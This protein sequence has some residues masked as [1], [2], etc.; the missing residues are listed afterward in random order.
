MER[1]LI[2]VDRRGKT[3][4]KYY[5]RSKTV[6][7]RGPKT[8]LKILNVLY[9]YYLHRLFANFR[10][11]IVY[12]DTYYIIP[13]PSLGKRL[14]NWRQDCEVVWSRWRH[15]PHHLDYLVVEQNARSHEHI[16]EEGEHNMDK[17]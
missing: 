4:V 9:T 3:S 12:R 15:V 8:V 5:E 13:Q 14:V 6:E 2:A 7:V 1:A 17:W 16:P 11:N 10:M